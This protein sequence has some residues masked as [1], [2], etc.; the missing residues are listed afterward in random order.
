MAENS[1]MFKNVR[2]VKLIDDDL[3]LFRKTLE[4]RMFFYQLWRKKCEECVR[5]NLFIRKA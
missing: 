5:R 1:I 2:I 3:L 4:F